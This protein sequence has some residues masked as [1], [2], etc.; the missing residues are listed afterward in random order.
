M[1]DRDG[2]A[3]IKDWIQR[4]P[5]EAEV[6]RG[7]IGKLC[8]VPGGPFFMGSSFHPREAPRREVNLPEFKIA[9]APVT[10][11]QFDDFLQAGGYADA[12]WW[13]SAGWAWRQGQTLGWGRAERGRPDAWLVQSRRPHHPVTGVTVYEAEAYCRWL[14]GQ[15]G[16]PIGLPSEEQWEKAARGDDGRVWPWGDDFRPGLANLAESE[17]G[18]TTPAGDVAGDVSPCGAVDMGGNVQEWTASGYTPLRGESFAAGQEL[19]VARGGSFRDTEFG[20]RTSYR[21]GYSAAYFFD[22][23][24]FRVAVAAG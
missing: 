20:A 24:G 17:L 12:R 11:Q 19:R 13:S 9:Y 7:S 15:R 21:R 18:D 2:A 8:P 6:A 16:Q 3:F 23:L 1:S 5:G 4:G 10:V 14:G 22:F